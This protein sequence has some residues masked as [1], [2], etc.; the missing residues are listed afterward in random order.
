MP[1]YRSNRGPAVKRRF[2][3]SGTIRSLLL[4]LALIPAAASLAAQEVTGRVVQGPGDEPIQGAVVSLVDP[5]DRTAARAMTDEDGAFAVSPQGPGRFSLHVSPAGFA[6]VRTPSFPL[7]A[8]E[9]RSFVVE[10][11][12]IPCPGKQAGDSVA[13]IH[14]SVRRWGDDRPVSGARVI[15]AWMDGPEV[16]GKE[17]TRMEVVAD[18]RGRYTACPVPRGSVASVHAEDVTGESERHWVE[19]LVQPSAER[20][21]AIGH[22]DQIVALEGIDVEVLTE[23][24]QRRRLGTVGLRVVADDDLE[25]FRR[26]GA[27]V[28]DVLRAR[29]AGVRIVEGR[30]ATAD[31]PEPR[32]M[33]CVEY[34]RGRDRLTL[35]PEMPGDAEL[36]EM[37]AVVVDGNEVQD[38][39]SYLRNLSLEHF[40]SVELLSPLPGYA[41][42]GFTARNGVI[43]LQTRNPAAG[44]RQPGTG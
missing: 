42:F 34:A 27:T 16:A 36:C 17:L 44:R 35:P 30:F 31:D 1:A 40:R 14:G 3:A 7:S 10:V 11:P 21:L 43:S 19:L 28:V 13:L 23:L 41:R 32:P 25:A 6:D 4:G 15:V 38:P 5:A 22:P 20:D 37:L 9:Q 12:L 29:M 26:R 24:E 8:G 18:A 2:P 39:G 33:V